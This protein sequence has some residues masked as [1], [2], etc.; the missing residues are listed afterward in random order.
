MGIESLRK[1]SIRLTGYLEQLLISELSEL[2]AIFTPKDPNQRGCQLSITIALDRLD[3]ALGIESVDDIV[4]KLK[5]KGVICDAR[6]PDVMRVA[7]AP[8]YNSFEDVFLFV[9]A[10]KSVLLGDS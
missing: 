8:L 7:P 3:K 9:S 10:L 2:V 4:V 1:K 5:E 6:K